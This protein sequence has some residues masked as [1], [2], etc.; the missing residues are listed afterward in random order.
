M[1]KHTK[2]VDRTLAL[3]QSY[4]KLVSTRT[5]SAEMPEQFLINTIT[6]EVVPIPVGQVLGVRRLKQHT[7]SLL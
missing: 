2:P 7:M 1:P 3:P 5:P 4:I 6:S